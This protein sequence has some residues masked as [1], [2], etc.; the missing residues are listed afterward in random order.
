[1]IRPAFP[2]VSDQ[3]DLSRRLRCALD[4]VQRALVAAI[5]RA[6]D[7]SS[8]ECAVRPFSLSKVV[9]ETAM[10]VRCAAMV[11]PA[12]G[13]T[14]ALVDEIARALSPYARG[15]LVKAQMC[16]D[17]GRAFEHASAHLYLTDIGYRDDGFG[18]YLDDITG[19]SPACSPERLPNHALEQ[20]WL[21]QIHAGVAGSSA[22]NP[23]A[24]ARTCVAWSLDVLGSSTMDLYAFTHV[25]LYASDMGHRAATWPRPLDAIVADAEAALA[26]ALDAD[27]FDLAAELLWTWPMLGLPWSPVAGFGYQVLIDAADEAGFLPGPDLTQSSAENAVKEADDGLALRTSY[28]AT[29]ALGIFCSAALRPGRLPSCEIDEPCVGEDSVDALLQ[30]LPASSRPRRWLRVLAKLDPASRG[31]LAPLVA[32]I[33]LRRAAAASDLNGLRNGIE[34]AS[35]AGVTDGPAMRQALAL[36]RRATIFA[37]SCEPVA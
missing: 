35:E 10:L 12:D 24:L 29:L 1:V 14:V 25:I 32:S 18:R 5:G 36:L 30:L 37:R 26:V 33:A 7:P 3:A 4:F 2:L 31:A 21:E 13:P 9:A 17:P 23:D 27:N 20:H 28:H 15:G 11:T 8:G 6:D 34:V 19:C 22:I 16:H